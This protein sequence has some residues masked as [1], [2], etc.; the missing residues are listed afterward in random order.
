MRLLEGIAEL[1][2]P[3]R[4]AGCDLPGT[5]MCDDCRAVL[6]RFAPSE[7]CPRCGAPFGALV[8]TE[9]WEHE[10]AFEA[11]LALG[12]LARPLARAVVLH[13]DGGER[14][15]GPELGAML[16]R[17]VL[18]QWPEWPDAV[19]WIPPTPEALIR[20]GFDHGGALAAPVAAAVSRPVTV[21]LTRDAALDQRRLSRAARARNAADTFCAVTAP[22]RRILLV[23][24][25]LTTGAT[26]DAASGALL[27][28]G[29]EAVRVAVVARAW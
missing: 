11:A 2:A 27:D 7:C 17:M 1:L 29:A 22:P 10:F 24:D 4:C 6:A 23:D 12:E 25:V 28:A 21:L 26:L 9:C 13:K 20:R 14:R 16:G 5:L 15:L 18:E 8:C 3:T 19:A